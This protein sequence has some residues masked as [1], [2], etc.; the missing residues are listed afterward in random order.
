[1]FSRV[2][3]VALSRIMIDVLRDCVCSTC[4]CTES[5][6]VENKTEILLI[7]EKHNKMKASFLVDDKPY[8]SQRIT[9]S[10]LVVVRTAVF[11]VLLLTSDLCV[12]ISLSAV[13][14]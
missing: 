13:Y 6:T 9:S 11:D 2:R 14:S 3:I 7:A 10:T 5:C 4:Y 1:M 12:C 8:M